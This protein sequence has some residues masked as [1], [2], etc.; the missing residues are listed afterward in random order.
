MSYLILSV[1][2]N[3]FLF[4][5]FKLV[6]QW[7]MPTFQVLIVNYFVAF[8]VGLLVMQVDFNIKQIITA[9]WFGWSIFLGFLF[10]SV[11]FI[12]GKTAQTLG[13]SV[14]SVA[15]KM[16]LII[17]VL[18]GVVVFKDHLNWVN[19]LGII[20]ALIAVYLT[21]KRDQGALLTKQQL[22]LPL[23]LFLGAGI[24]DS[25]LKV[26]QH[27]YVSE[28]DITLFS[29]TTFFTAGSVG[30]VSFLISMAKQQ[31]T[32][33][34]SSFLGGILL[35]VPNFFAIYCMFKMLE[36]PT[37]NSATI[38]TFHNVAIVLVS[39]LAGIVFFKEQ[40]IRSNWIGIALSILALV[41]VT[42]NF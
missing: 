6:G 7:Q 24:I 28:E 33:K 39:T 8:L 27:L 37:W 4:V 11:F 31:K 41:L 25:L 12:T 9:D 17:P 42:L 1:L 40:L 19:I 10:I 32:F 35:G 22:W 2:L 26:V 23:V 16:S 15:S 36:H 14:A 18:S 38:F 34:K 21:T 20:T 3:S 13:L 30:L 5:V 29:V